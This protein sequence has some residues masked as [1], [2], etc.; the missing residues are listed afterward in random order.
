MK[1]F[2]AKQPAKIGTW[3]VRTLYQSGKSLQVAKEMDRYNL[4]ILGLS[5]VRW[6][7]SGMTT[8]T[9]GHTII[10]SGNPNDNDIHD[11]GVGFALT[12]K[13]KRSLL[14]WNPVSFRIITARF[15][16]KFQK[17]TKIQ[18]YSPTKNASEE[19]KEEFYD[20]L[21]TIVNLTPKRDIL[22]IIGDLNAK[23]GAN[24]NGI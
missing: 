8:L 4:Q 23:V 22:M 13:A 21:Q 7:T 12:K 14:E 1:L 19:E 17:T 5:E 15:D 18:V 24:G 16:T 3:N 2:S 10:Y 9:S 11:K 6:N 20:S